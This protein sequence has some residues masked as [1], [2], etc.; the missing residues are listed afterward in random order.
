[1]HA[2]VVKEVSTYQSMIMQYARPF[3]LPV[4]AALE[5]RCLIRHQLNTDYIIP[6]VISES[7]DKCGDL[8]DVVHQYIRIVL[9]TP[10]SL[11]HNTKLA[12]LGNNNC[13][14]DRIMFFKLH[15]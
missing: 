3:S 6:T 14:S 7:L 13:G 11:V 9:D 2:S 10:I 4:A 8:F 15:T 5:K 12:L 1:M